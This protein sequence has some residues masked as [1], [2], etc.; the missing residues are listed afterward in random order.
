MNNKFTENQAVGAIVAEFPR[1]AEIFKQYRIDFCCGGD[2]SLT[3]AANELQLNPNIV[4]NDLNQAYG[5]VEKENNVANE[6]DWRGQPMSQLVDYIVDTHH[7][8]LQREMPLISEL[9]VKVLRVHGA[10]HSELKDVHKLFHILKMELEQ[11]LI[12][13]EETLFPL[14]K[15]YESNPSSQLLSKIKNQTNEIESEHEQAGGIIKELRKIT[16]QYAVVP[17]A[18][19]SFRLVYQKLEE[20]ESDIFRHIHLENNILHPRLVGSN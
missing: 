6:I 4:L 7:I 17:D 11:H 13:E 19:T 15:E 10:N 3:V 14:I 9:I 12:T 5:S 16:N 2:K 1:A 18:C 20:M 8:Y